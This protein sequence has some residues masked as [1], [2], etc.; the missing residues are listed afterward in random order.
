VKVLFLHSSGD[1]IAGSELVLLKLLR[2]LSGAVECAVALPGEGRFF[3]MLGDEGVRVVS[4][5]LEA[6]E[7]LDPRP[8][9]SSLPRFARL[10]QQEAPDLVHTSS[11]SPVQYAWPACSQLGVPLVCHLQ[12]PYE[13]D[14]I[15]LLQ[16][17]RADRII[18]L[19]R[20]IRTMLEPAVRERA[21]VIHSGVELPRMLTRQQ[22]AGV[23][24]ELGLASEAPVVCYA[25]QLIHRKGVDT[26]MQALGR[27]QR[28]FP[29]I[30]LVMVGRDD[31]A[32]AGELRAMAAPLGIAQRITWTGFRDDVQRLMAAADLVAV[33]SRSEGLGRVA[34]EALAVGTPVVASRTGGLPEMVEDGRNGF[35]VP[36]G[37]PDRL[38]DGM[39]L[40]L[41]NPTVAASMG[42]R[43]RKKMAAEFSLE[44]ELQQVVSE[45]EALLAS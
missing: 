37:S 24:A 5:G 11:A 38:A 26:L 17:H 22:R 19:S 7:S 21:T 10:L 1:N 20:F 12:A 39:T 6:T 30:Q 29:C 9:V 32:Y 34:A 8:L 42:R 16:V 25:G 36:V 4:A 41:A 15:S 44:Q 13:A 27:L 31:S 45:Y 18:A 33:P 40:L 3:S 23:R 28:I 35:L 43:G 2:G 14:E